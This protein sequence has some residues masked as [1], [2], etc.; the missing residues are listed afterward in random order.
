MTAVTI[1]R[2]PSPSFCVTRSRDSALVPVPDGGF[3]G[4]Y[5]EIRSFGRRDSSHRRGPR[6][7]VV[8]TDG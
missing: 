6:V 8:V 3:D 1:L 4:R 2:R 5:T 7:P